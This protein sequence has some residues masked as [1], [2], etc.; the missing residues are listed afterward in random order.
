MSRPF[1]INFRNLTVIIREGDLPKSG[2]VT[3][4]GTKERRKHLEQYHPQLLGEYDQHIKDFQKRFNEIDRTLKL[5][6]KWSQHS[7]RRKR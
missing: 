2:G 5:G 3:N 6:K 1:H 4:F 7:K